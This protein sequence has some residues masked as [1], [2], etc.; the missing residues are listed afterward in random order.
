MWVFHL[1]LK[2]VK[3]IINL[4]VY[5][6]L[7]RNMNHSVKTTSKIKRYHREKKLRCYRPG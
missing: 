1:Q 6:E 4:S 5:L 3:N 2:L 7:S